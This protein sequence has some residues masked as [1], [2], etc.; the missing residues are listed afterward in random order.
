MLQNGVYINDISFPNIKA[1]QLYIK[2]NEKLSVVVKELDLKKSSSNKK[3]TI[4]LQ[5]ID[6][7]LQEILIF[8][9]L[10]EKILIENIHFNDI[11][12]SFKY[13]DGENGYLN[14][15]SPEFKLNTS[16]FFESHLFNIKI[17]SLVDEKKEI[18]INGNIILNTY[19]TAELVTSLNINI[20]KNI[21]LHLYAST[22]LNKLSYK[23]EIKNDIKSVKPIIDKYASNWDA[24]WWVRDAINMSS[25]TI[26]N[27]NGYLEYENFKDAY[28]HLHVDAI[29][30]DL[31]YT[32]NEKLDVIDTSHTEL[33]FKDGS[34]YIRPKNAYT[35][36][37]FLD[38]S[39]LKIDFT[40]VNAMVNL[41]LLFQ[42]ML[43]KDLLYLLSVYDIDLPFIQ[44]KGEL[45]TDLKLD[46]NL[47]TTDVEAHG[48]FYTDDAWI[49]YLGL[50]LNVFDTNVVLD[51]TNVSVKNMFVKYDDIA[52]SHLDILFDAKK[53]IG[54]LDFRLD[55]TAFKDIRVKL[56]NKDKPLHVEYLINP[57]QDYI[58]IDKS[59][60]NANDIIV[61]LDAMKLPF[62][63]DTVTAIVPSTTLKSTDIVS[64]IV[65]GKVLFKPLR[66]KLNLDITTLNR[67][68]TTLDQENLKI[69][70]DY[71]KDMS[72]STAQTIRLKTSEDIYILNNMNINIANKH[73]KIKK[74]SL[75]AENLFTSNMSLDYDLEKDKGLLDINNIDIQNKTFQ[76]I[77]KINKMTKLDIE[78][79]NNNII[80]S[81]KDY[82]IQYTLNNYEWKVKVN[83]VKNIANKSKL[84]TK[85]F[86]DNGSFILEKKYHQNYMDFTAKTNYK[87][88]LL[89]L[90]NKPT[91][92][93]TIRGKINTKNNDINMDINNNFNI[94]I[95]DDIQMKTKNIGLNLDNI[96]SL[97]SDVKTSDNNNNLS[98]HFNSKN[99]YVF[100]SDKRHAI[101][102]T[103]SFN[104]KDKI[105]D[106]TLKHKKGIATFKYIDNK[107]I[108][109]GKQFN[110][111]FMT[112]LF[113]LSEVKNGAFGFSIAGTTKKYKGVMYIKDATIIDY[114]I[115]NNVLA[116]VNTVPA[117]LT[118][119]LPGYNNNGLDINRLYFD[120]EFEND[121]YNVSSFS[122]DSKEL[123]ILGKG[124][125]SI[126]N[127]TINMDMNLK[128]DLGSS[129]SKIPLVGYI[130]LGD[131]TVS[132]SLTLTG[133]LDD[134]TVD[135]QVA[136]DIAVAPWNILKRTLTYPMKLFES[137][138]N[139]K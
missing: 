122:I 43:N 2:W 70:I 56:I 52:T 128:T 53:D 115:L 37:M 6:T 62:D 120:F 111:K 5:K 113:A 66:A 112:N 86:I 4:Q 14:L 29:V 49:N 131:D 127:N 132:T 58:I 51:N 67:Y 50:D 78:N 63:I 73:V 25:L 35:Y 98:V 83:S 38:K 118:F 36:K 104:Y 8:D 74:M 94:I 15:S 60:W 91:S 93:Y 47:K 89:V 34:L 88:K 55:S 129:I 130:L 116:F 124:E 9:T 105:L 92:N 107:F 108:L 27:V 30:N 117:L 135:T 69:R 114:K 72:I 32:Y 81:S 80:I 76:E 19:N 21:D 7:I 119:S 42:G 44:T 3:S 54:K 45:K 64:S 23:I 39:W 109:K 77:F 46:I 13:L 99:S 65:S 126:K 17:D 18:S 102:D 133:K 11:S 12:G 138:E 101:S 97:I 90:D 121:I 96:L 134:P 68:N 110:D 125:A 57:K 22:N 10:F 75:S 79:K 59:T 85:Y 1:K 136:K 24:K 123:K 84:L 26:N 40:K 95:K 28:K 33:E 16:L 71:D 87:Y 41:H 103:I 48:T 31:K 61:N 139:K 106:A 20:L 100:F 137:D 82:D